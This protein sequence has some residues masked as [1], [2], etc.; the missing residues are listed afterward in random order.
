MTYWDYLEKAYPPIDNDEARTNERKLL[1]EKFARPGGPGARFKTYLDKMVKSLSLPKGAKEEL[2]ISG[3]EPLQ[4]NEEEEE[5]VARERKEKL[6]QDGE[7][8]MEKEA[9]YD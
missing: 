7:L 2:G 3:D 1:M 5:R 6:S 9:E 8:D 4:Y